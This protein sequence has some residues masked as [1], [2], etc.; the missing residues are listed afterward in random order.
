M[1]RIIFYALIACVL[2]SSA[3]AGFDEGVAAYQ[4]GD[5]PLAVKEFRSA[6]EEG[7]AD[8]QFNFALMHERGIGVPKNEQEAVAWYRKSAEQG[9]SNAQYNLAVMYENGR[10]CAVDFT[11]ANH[12]YR[13]AA[14][15]GDGLAV[16]NLGMLYL[17]GEG[18]EKDEVAGL[19]L[20]LRSVMLDG[21]PGNNARQNISGARGLAPET[22]KAAE[23]L[24]SEM[25]GADNLLTPLDRYLDD[26]RPNAASASE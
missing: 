6:A 11:Q 21:S 13:K 12:W 19:A 5:L 16:G 9:S 17:R 20:L 23:V 14:V 8:G 1:K 15:Q 3:L 7:D 4:A 10:G 2:S 22:I 24:A 18:V 25:G 26:T